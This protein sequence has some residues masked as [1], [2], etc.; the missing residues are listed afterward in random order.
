MIN[1]PAVRVSITDLLWRNGLKV[2]NALAVPLITPIQTVFVP[3]TSDLLWHALLNQGALKGNLWITWLMLR[4]VEDM[5]DHVIGTMMD[6][7]YH[8]SLGLDQ[9]GRWFVDI[10]S[11]RGSF[12]E[13]FIV[14]IEAVSIEV[15]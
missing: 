8:W 9:W 12:T 1:I 15:A 13:Y 2:V 3:V 11:C 14:G 6:G 7:M 10:L 5:R 4:W